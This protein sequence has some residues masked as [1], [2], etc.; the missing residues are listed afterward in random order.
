MAWA[1]AFKKKE[2]TP[3]RNKQTTKPKQMTM[4]DRRCA[5]Y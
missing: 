2:T 5:V 3:H 1:N 4:G